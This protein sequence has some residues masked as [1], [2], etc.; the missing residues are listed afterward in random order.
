MREFDRGAGGPAK[1]MNL[2]I[3]HGGAPTAVLN[4][5][6][7]GTVQEA[8]AR[9]EIGC[10]Y[11]ALGGSKAVT[12]GD[13]LDLRTVP[14]RQLE[15]LLH[16]PSSAIGTSRDH[17]EPAD[18]D[19]IAAC[20]RAKEIT[21]V[22]FNGGNG[23]MDACGK[24][25]AAC[26]RLG[27]D[28]RVV[29]IPKTM[30]NDIAVT[31]HSPGYGSAARYMAGSVAEVCCDVRGLPIH[32]VVVEAMGRSA[33]WV[34]AASA[35]AEDCGTGGPDLIYLPEQPFDQTAFLRDVQGLIDRKG[36]GVV[37]A[38]EGLRDKNGQPIVPPVMT[39]G[40]ATYFGDVSA[41][42]ANLIVR[43]LGWKARSEKPGI[44]GRASIA[45][46]S[47]TDRREAELV[48][49]EAVKAVCEGASGV[50]I[51]LR[52]CQGTAY[53][54]DTMQVPIEQVMLT[55]RKMPKEFINR[56]GNGVTEEFKAWCRPLVGP[57]PRLVSFC[58]ET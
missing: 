48:G 52:R 37:V 13:L 17:L 4:A 15:M 1:K 32:V 55:E 25:D 26:R 14:D 12:R 3:V 20:L 50:M 16:S 19:A 53:R 30:D 21:A 54:V 47:E 46:Q 23:S 18:Y 44:L 28:I 11:G 43:E 40:R 57:L 31:D 58:E 49:R 42:L 38:S 27:M 36:C 6:L 9:P 45:W 2:L 5:S 35:L 56:A 51:G 41:H 7:Y 34:A 33:G 10:I 39:V 29:G 24:V 22:C 8:K